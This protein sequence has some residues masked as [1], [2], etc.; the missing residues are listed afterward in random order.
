M[1]SAETN[2][3]E[4]I[5]QQNVSSIC[6][7]EVVEISCCILVIGIIYFVRVPEHSV[8]PNIAAVMIIIQRMLA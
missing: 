5:R 3:K 2:N 1:T 7:T 6:R 4:A 8:S